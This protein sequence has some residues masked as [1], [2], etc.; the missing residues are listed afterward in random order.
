MMLTAEQSAELKGRFKD[1]FNDNGYDSLMSE[2]LIALSD[3]YPLEYREACQEW[4]RDH[5]DEEDCQ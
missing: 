3:K 4:E 5:Q 2:E 1:W